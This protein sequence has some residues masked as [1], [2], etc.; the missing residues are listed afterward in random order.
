MKLIGFLVLHLKAY[1]KKSKESTARYTKDSKRPGGG[2]GF[3]QWINRGEEPM[4]LSGNKEFRFPPT[5]AQPYVLL[6]LT[7][8][9]Y[10]AEFPR[11]RQ[12]FHIYKWSALPLT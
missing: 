9:G 3:K 7:P 6:D 11:M 1:H 4:E 2:S 5:T 8:G 10:C 12:W